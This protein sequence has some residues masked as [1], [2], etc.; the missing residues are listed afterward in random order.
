MSV[1]RNSKKIVVL[2]LIVTVATAG[3]IYLLSLPY[4]DKPNIIIISLDTCRSDHLSCYGFAQKITPTI[5]IIAQDGILF[6]HAYTPYPM[7]LPAHSS[8]FTGLYPPGHHVLDNFSYQLG[9]DNLTLAEIMRDNQYATGAIIS[10][11]VLNRKFGVDQ[12]FSE[13]NDQFDNPIGE[14]NALERRGD[15]TGRYACQ[16]LTEHQREPFFLFLHFYDPHFAYNP[17]EPFASDYADNLYAGEIAY[18]DHCLKQVYDKL[19]ELDLY[20]STLIIIAGDHGESLGEHGENLHGYYIYNC[21]THVP[22]IIKPPKKVK[23]TSIENAVSLVDIV[24]TVLGYSHIDCP[25]GLHG[26]DLGQLI[27]GKSPSEDNRQVFTESLM[28][29]KYDCNPLLGLISAQWNY[30]E[31]TRPEIYDFSRDP[32]ELNNLIDKES[33]RAQL[34]QYNLQELVKTFVFSASED[35]TLNLDAE[36]QRNLESLGYVGTKTVNDSFE[37]DQN[38]KDP[39]DM[40]ACHEMYLKA[41]YLVF[42]KKY[43]EARIV[44][45]KT[46]QQ[47]PEVALT[48]YLLINIASHDENWSEMSNYGIKFL[49]LIMEK[50][51]N[52]L[53]QSKNISTTTLATAHHFVGTANY[54]LKNYDLAIKHW[55]ETLKFRENWPEVHNKLAICYLQQSDTQQAI[56]HWRRTLELA[57]DSTEVRTNLTN[58]YD[59]LAQAFYK[60][61]DIDQ[62][63]DY[64]LQAV[65]LNPNRADVH[66]NLATAFYRQNKLDLALSHWRKALN[67]KPEWPEVLNNVSWL[68]ATINDPSLNNPKEAVPL[69]RQAAQLTKNQNPSILDTLSVVYAANGQFTEAIKTAESALQLALEQNNTDLAESIRQHLILFKAGKTVK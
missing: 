50:Q 36:T 67:L 68:L 31:T 37:F 55:T 12:G 25:P 13:Y 32:G 21:T 9:A 10:S 41:S 53:S 35:N 39:K 29:T 7:T 27:N 33:Q 52:N 44:C 66:N 61:N 19:H 15:E 8:L 28:P 42:D 20:D 11:F 45:E 64:W 46:L 56:V 14:G 34:M 58:L 38:K 49:T 30:I 3:A 54:N 1:K 5:D 63:V 17:P 47:W 69:A 2:I 22:L 59:T 60:V 26:E 18:M 6:Q 51:Q 16:Y 40:I 62:A 4:L 23:P 65:E 57:P 43:A 24:P 48:Y